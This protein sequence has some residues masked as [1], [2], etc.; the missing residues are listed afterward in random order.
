MVCHKAD[1]TGVANMHP[2]LTPGS[3]VG[4]D[5]AE[6]I[7]IMM[8][9]LSGR[10]EVDDE[11]YNNFMPSHARLTDEEIANVLS[12]IRSSFGNNFPPVTTEMVAKV[13]SGR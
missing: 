9:G 1:G 6:L 7:A 12:Y 11:E 2:P 10:I 13:R 8:K 4:K 3:W 5:P